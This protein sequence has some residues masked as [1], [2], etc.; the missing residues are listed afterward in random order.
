[1]TGKIVEEDNRGNR[2][3]QLIGEG[4]LGRQ[5]KMAIELIG[6]GR[7]SIKEGNR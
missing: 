1:M 5:S 3:R 4:G 6:E 7:Q 2:R